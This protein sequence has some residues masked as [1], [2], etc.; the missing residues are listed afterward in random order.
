MILDGANP[1]DNKNNYS[2]A[3]ISTNPI[4]DT[5]RSSNN[6]NMKKNNFS[7]IDEEDEGT[8]ANQPLQFFFSMLLD[9]T[10]IESVEIVE[11]NARL[12]HDSM[13]RVAYGNRSHTSLLLDDD[14]DDIDCTELPLLP[15]QSRWGS[16][17][18]A[19]SSIALLQP[20]KPQR[21][22]SIEL[23]SSEQAQ[24]IMAN[25][26]PPLPPTRWSSDEAEKSLLNSPV[27]STV[28]SMKSDFTKLSPDRGL[29][30][31]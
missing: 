20:C 8:M 14:D 28:P 4:K 30:L 12:P 26:C 1:Q 18:A 27:R 29:L 10:P 16:E 6:N 23:P 3:T 7:T 25:C 19:A 11:D 17:P 31:L 21:K 22:C 2:I 13:T 15:D 5:T 9:G 24:M